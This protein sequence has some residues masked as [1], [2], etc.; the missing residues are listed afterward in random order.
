MVKTVVMHTEVLTYIHMPLRLLSHTHSLLY[1][2]LP[3]MLQTGTTS[4]MANC[5]PPLCARDRIRGMTRHENYREPVR[6]QWN[7]IL[8]TQTKQKKE[9]KSGVKN[10]AIQATLFD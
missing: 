3:A 2:Y 9:L 1:A 4:G 5:S 7:R 10:S 8:I 6:A